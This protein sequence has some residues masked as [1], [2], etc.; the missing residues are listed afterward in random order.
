MHAS[1]IIFYGQGLLFVGHSGA[2]K[3]TMLK[4]LKEDGEIL[5]DDRMIVR[6]G[7]D[8]FRIHGTWSHGE[9]PDISPASA[10]LRG[11][12]Y[13]RQADKNAL[14]PITNSQARLSNILSYI[15]KPL[16]T[17]DWW[18]KILIVAEK[19]ASE[20]PAYHLQFDLSGDVVHLLNQL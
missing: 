11:I 8:G 3:S 12:F 5:C 14:I 6:R 2:G 18:E 13:L 20:V 7:P 17:T 4:L 19:V 16:Q 1:G 9:L 15:I 10:P